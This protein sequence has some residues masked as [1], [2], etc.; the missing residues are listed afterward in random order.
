MT[1]WQGV[2]WGDADGNLIDHAAADLAWLLAEVERL[3]Q[4]TAHDEHWRRQF[5]ALRNRVRKAGVSI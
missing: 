2:G 1:L 3:R 5:Y 4:L